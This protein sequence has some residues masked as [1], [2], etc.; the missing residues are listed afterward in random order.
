MDADDL[1]EGERPMSRFVVGIPLVLRFLD[2]AGGPVLKRDIDEMLGREA[3]P[4]IARW[5]GN[6]LT[7][8]KVRGLVDNPE[9]ATWVLTARG[10]ATLLLQPKIDR[11]VDDLTRSLDAG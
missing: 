10:S 8:M 4:R 7:E 1:P 3:P 6:I 9:W 5:G 11:M 2:E